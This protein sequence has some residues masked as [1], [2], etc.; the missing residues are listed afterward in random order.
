MTTLEPHAQLIKNSFNAGL[1]QAETSWCS[2]W[3]RPA[4]MEMSCRRFCDMMWREKDAELERVLVGWV[5][6]QFSTVFLVSDTFPVYFS[7]SALLQCL[8]MNISFSQISLAKK[9]LRPSSIPLLCPDVQAARGDQDKENCYSC[10][11]RPPSWFLIRSKVFICSLMILPLGKRIEG[12]TSQWMESH[13][14]RTISANWIM[15]WRWILSV[16]LSCTR[17]RFLI[18]YPV[19]LW[20]YV[21]LRRRRSRLLTLDR[22]YVMQA[23]KVLFHYIVFALLALTRL[24]SPWSWLFSITIKYHLSLY[25]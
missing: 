9:D 7:F 3:R 14:E 10:R 8:N 1:T 18:G 4:V 6:I 19:V 2:R 25:Y 21:P 16:A 24:D 17:L 13:D 11:R 22:K 23:L 15:L 12:K 5:F 20:W